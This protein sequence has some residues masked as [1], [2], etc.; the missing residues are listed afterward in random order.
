MLC[1]DTASEYARLIALGLAQGVPAPA[2][3][4]SAK[5]PLPLCRIEK[6]R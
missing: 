5:S 6:E 2:G 3:S 1:E 4:L